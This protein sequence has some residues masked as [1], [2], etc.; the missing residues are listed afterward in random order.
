MTLSTRTTLVMLSFGLLLLSAILFRSFILDYL[1]PPIAL[2][3]WVFWRFVCTIDQTVYWFVLIMSALF[4]G[5][6]HLVRV[7]EKQSVHEPTLPADYNATLERI[8]YWRDSVRLA[9]LGKFNILE[10]HLGK[11]LAEIYTSQQPNAVYFEVYAA[12]EAHHLPLPQPID[13]FLFPAKPPGSRRPFRRILQT[14]WN[15]PPKQ[16]RR[17]TGREVAEYYQSLEQVITYMEA[18]LEQKT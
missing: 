9:R 18:S 15:W 6:V 2:V 10:N 13:T 7:L 5:L 12:L 8:R 11:M 1:A 17:W 3:L 14:I 4:A 16:I